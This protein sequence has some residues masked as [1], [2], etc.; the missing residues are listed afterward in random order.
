MS[1]YSKAQLDKV[2]LLQLDG[3]GAEAARKLVG[4]SHTPAELHAFR[5]AWLC[6][7]L[8]QPG[9]GEWAFSTSL[10]NYLRFQA[11]DDRGHTGW[12]IGKIMVA[13]DATEGKVRRA[14]REGGTEDRGHRTGKGG[15]FFADNAKLYEETLRTDGTRVPTGKMAE[16]N[17]YA[18]MQ[19]LVKKDFVELKAEAVEAGLVPANAKGLTKAKLAKLLAEA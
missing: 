17:G 15:R 8:P 4:V 1:K 5:F 9:V 14:I 13:L 10:V 16:A 3:T 7:E 18:T 2:I 19:R 12:G 6:S 11:T